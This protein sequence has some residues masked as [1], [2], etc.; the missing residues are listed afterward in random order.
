MIVIREIKC[1]CCRACGYHHAA[2]GVLVEYCGVRE[3][4][5]LNSFHSF[6]ARLSA[7]PG[8]VEV[9]AEATARRVIEL[10]APDRPA[11]GQR[12]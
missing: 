6:L 12:A 1:D 7:M 9:L 8:V 3:F 10:P 5:C 2:P 11:L 4:H